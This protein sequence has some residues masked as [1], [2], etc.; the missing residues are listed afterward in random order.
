MVSRKSVTVNSFVAPATPSECF[1]LAIEASRIA[2]KYMT[3]VAYLSDAFL[4][5]GSEPWRLPDVDSLPRIGVP[6]ATDANA[7]DPCIPDS[8]ALLCTRGDADGERAGRLRPRRERLRQSAHQRR[9]LYKRPNALY[10]P[11]EEQ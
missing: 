7:S 10:L 5:T 1:D 9:F 11:K 2:L 6:N 3:P 8:K 4:A